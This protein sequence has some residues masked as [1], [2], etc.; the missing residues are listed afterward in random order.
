MAIPFKVFMKKNPN[1]RDAVPRFY[2][3]LITMGQTATL[4]TIAYDM[5]ESSSLSIGDIKSVL[6]NFVISMRRALYNGHSVN[7]AGFGVFRLTSHSEGADTADSCSVKNI[8]QVNISF[9]PSNSIRPSLTAKNEGDVMSF[10][11]VTKVV[12]GEASGGSKV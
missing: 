2:P 3:Q 9:R 10:V 7:I 1:D 5:K 12:E 11:D 6:A 8:K 4:E